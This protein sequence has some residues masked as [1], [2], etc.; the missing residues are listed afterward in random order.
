METNPEVQTRLVGDVG[1][2]IDTVDMYRYIDINMASL[3]ESWQWEDE[4]TKL[5][6]QQR[7]PQRLMWRMKDW[8]W[9]EDWNWSWQVGMGN[10]VT[11]KYLSF[12]SQ[13]IS[14]LS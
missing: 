7:A 9:S 6:W 11:Y 13:M 10:M 14:N 2:V 12:L 4:V 1:D 8:N 5:L 3:G